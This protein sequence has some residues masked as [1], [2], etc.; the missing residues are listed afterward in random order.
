MDSA[1]YD[2]FISHASEDKEAF[3]RPLAGMLHELGLAIWYDEHSLRIGDSLSA[4]IDRGLRDAKYGLVVLS[5]AFLKK[6]WPEYEYRSLVTLEGDG[7][8]RILPVWLDVDREDIIRFSP[9][10]ADKFAVQASGSPRK[11]AFA[12]LEVVRPEASR[13]FKRRAALEPVRK[14]SDDLVPAPPGPPLLTSQLRRLNLIR[15]A[16]FETYPQAWDEMVTDFRRDIPSE[17]DSEIG[18]WE[19]IAGIY[20]GTCRRF[21]LDGEEKRKL[22]H[23]LLRESLGDEIAVDAVQPW[24]RWA[25]EAI[26]AEL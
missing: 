5:P 15:E 20:L 16:L 11:A 19:S 17:R 26:R 14:S 7:S 23:A 22:F 8:K 2:L 12:V 13:E 25:R 3:V 24:L 10:L 21:T 6:P 9:H 18:T 4:S 1:T